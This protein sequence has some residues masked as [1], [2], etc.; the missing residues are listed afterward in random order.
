MR[1]IVFAAALVFV[2]F[3]SVSNSYSS[4]MADP[5]VFISWQSATGAGGQWSMSFP[6]GHE[7]RM[8]DK[9]GS[10]T[11]FG[12]A[13]V[14]KYGLQGSGLNYFNM[15]FNTDPYVAGGFAFTNGTLSTQTYTIIFQSPVIPIVP[16]TL[17]GGSMS[18]SF[19][20]DPTAATVTTTLNTPLYLGMIDGIP[21]LPIYNAPSSWSAAAYKSGSIAAVNMLPPTLIGPAANTD[22]AIQFKF[23]LTPG[24]T[25]TMNGA[26]E[27]IVPEPA[28]M[29]L[30][31]IGGLIAFKNSK[32]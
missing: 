17:Y 11:L 1:K 16:S 3:L 32:Q 8:G 5:Q 4:F 31:G 19:T 26:F 29:I 27:V 13:D 18:G 12:A 15:A 30:L 22:I 21:V 10:V 14:E 7:L 23:T 6:V 9:E 25:A 20:A 24:D 2:L 28:T